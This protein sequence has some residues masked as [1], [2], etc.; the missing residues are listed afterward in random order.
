MG[1]ATGSQVASASFT[2]PK[3]AA[4]QTRSQP[5]GSCC[6]RDCFHAGERD[7]GVIANFAKVNGP[8]GEM[9]GPFLPLVELTSRRGLWMAFALIATAAH[10]GFVALGYAAVLAFGTAAAFL[11]RLH[12]RFHVF[13]A[14]AGFA[15]LHFTLRVLFVFAATGAGILGVGCGVMAAACAIFH[16]G[17]V[18]M[19]TRFGLRGGCG[20]RSRRR[21]LRP[22]QQRQGKGKDQSNHSEFHKSPYQSYE[23]KCYEHSGWVRPV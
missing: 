10:G 9:S 7:G 14:A 15:V 4:I 8:D 13:T 3:K 19:T 5:A 1:V 11:A 17:H 18:V 6:Q 21:L 20:V 16:I 23:H 12:R 22:A 2:L